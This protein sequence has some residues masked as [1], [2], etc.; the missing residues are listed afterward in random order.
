[1]SKLERGKKIS[2]QSTKPS[3][4]F[5]V[6]RCSEILF[7]CHKKKVSLMVEQTWN[8]FVGGSKKGFHQNGR[9]IIRLLANQLTSSKPGVLKIFP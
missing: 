1:M 5:Y 9:N 3:Q 2:E 7:K 8:I 4:Y 6:N